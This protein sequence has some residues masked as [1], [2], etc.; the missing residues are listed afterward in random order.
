M[1]VLK[2]EV[3]EL[4]INAINCNKC[5]FKKVYRVN[6]KNKIVALK[7]AEELID[8]KMNMFATRIM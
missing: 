3:T 2:Q 8:I 5:I 6:Y 7:E 1:K 4:V